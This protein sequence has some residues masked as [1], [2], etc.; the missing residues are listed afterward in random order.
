MLFRS[1]PGMVSSLKGAWMRTSDNG[2]TVSALAPAHHADI[3]EGA[4][5]NDT[6][7]EVAAF[8]RSV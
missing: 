7:V 3:A 8:S 6:R 4:C 2:Q 1:R 5:Y